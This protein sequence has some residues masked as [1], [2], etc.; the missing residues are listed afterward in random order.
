MRTAIVL[1]FV[2]ALTGCVP[3]FLAVRNSLSE[4]VIVTSG[5]TGDSYRIKPN[6]T[7][8]VPHT[9]GSLTVATESGKTWQYPNVSSLDGEH[10]NHF[11][12]WNKVVKPF[13]VK[14]RVIPNQKVDPIN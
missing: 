12:F 4:P 11:I 3:T 7:H 10:K 5:H 6:R 2:V 9:T 8:K 1:M 13:D 14:E